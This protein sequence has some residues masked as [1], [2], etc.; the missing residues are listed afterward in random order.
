MDD[1]QRQGPGGNFEL[2]RIDEILDDRDFPR[3]PRPEPVRY[4]NNFESL[5]ERNRELKNDAQVLKMEEGLLEDKFRE[6]EE[7]SARL[8]ARANGSHVKT[9][10]HEELDK[11]NKEYKELKREYGKKYKQHEGNV[12]KLNTDLEEYKQHRT[13]LHTES[14]RLEDAQKALNKEFSDLEKN[15]NSLSHAEHEMKWRKLMERRIQLH[16]EGMNHAEQQAAHIGAQFSTLSERPAAKKSW[17]NFWDKDSAAP[18]QTTPGS[19]TTTAQTQGA[20]T[21]STNGTPAPGS[22]TPQTP[23][24]GST[25]KTTLNAPPAGQTTS[26]L[27]SVKDSAANIRAAFNQT[28]LTRGF[29]VGGLGLGGYGL[30]HSIQDGDAVGITLNSANVLTGGAGTLQMFMASVPKPIAFIGTKLNIPLTIAM[31]GYQVYAEKGAFI[32]TNS[33]G[34]HSL[35]SK[36]SRTLAVA[37]TVTA[38]VIT[39]AAGVAAAPAIVIVG[40]AAVVGETGVEMH[41]SY[42]AHEELGRL[43]KKAAEVS[44]NDSAEHEKSGAPSIRKYNNLTVFALGEAKKVNGTDQFEHVKNTNYSDQTTLLKLEQALNEQVAKL[45][46]TIDQNTSIVPDWL[47]VAGGDGAHKKLDAESKLAP[48]EAAQK[49]LALYKQDLI[50]YNEEHPQ[51]ASKSTHRGLAGSKGV[52]KGHFAHAA[53][54]TT[55][56]PVGVGGRDPSSR[57]KV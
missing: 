54:D 29:G 50:A 4:A 40:G 12:A 7:K 31:G 14:L 22:S 46:K 15:K 51:S 28:N 30:V 44:R 57:P 26:L 20:P 39:T 3:Q 17:F 49:E 11:L 37:G 18:T 27:S 23:V 43:N 33:D 24:A 53:P 32:D 10:Q 5:R 42:R 52:P 48:L 1:L 25:T 16:A 21:G 55:S 9:P 2:R 38:G 47:R 35:G 41:R 45:R 19:G 34:T 56:E 36:G 13:A 6:I 8:R